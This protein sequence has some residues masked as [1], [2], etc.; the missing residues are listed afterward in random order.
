MYFLKIAGL[1]FIH[2][3]W[4]DPEP[5]F[6]TQPAKAKNWQT[7]EAALKF[8]NQKLTPKLK[9]PWEVWHEVE[10]ELRPLMRPRLTR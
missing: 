3:S 4:K 1:G 6:C 5:R 8:G 9:I 2:K 10:D 7:L